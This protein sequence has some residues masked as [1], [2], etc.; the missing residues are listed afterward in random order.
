MAEEGGGGFFNGEHTLFGG[1]RG[2]GR[3]AEG[4]GGRGRGRR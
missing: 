3:G 4:E 2:R 1:G